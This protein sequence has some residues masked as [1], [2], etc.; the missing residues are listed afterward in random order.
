MSNIAKMKFLYKFFRKK[1]WQCQLGRGS[2]LYDSAQICNPQNNP[3]RI[4]IGNHTHI[5]GEILLFKHGGKVS[6]GDYCYLGEGSRIWSGI[7]ILIGDRVLISHMVSIYDN[8]THP[9]RADLRHFHY[10]EILVK[11]H[12][13]KI[14]L[15]E[16]RVEI[17]SD[18]WIGSHAVIL[19]G[20]K[21]GEGAVV[22]AGSIVTKD[23]Q[24]YTLVAGNPAKKIRALE[25]PPAHFMAWNE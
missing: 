4:Q 13:D 18:A 17:C 2:L 10:R 21:I 22:A 5:R 12:P 1:I 25:K 14:D 16:K 20:V 23:V 9:M 11:G 15:S 7:E 19:R 24:D 8:T 3:K 6:I